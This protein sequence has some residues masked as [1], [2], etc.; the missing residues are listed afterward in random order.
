MGA[1]KFQAIDLQAKW[2]PQNPPPLC[3]HLKVESER[4]V[5]GDVTDHNHCTRLWAVSSPL[6]R[7]ADPVR[8]KTHNG[9]V[10]NEAVEKA[11]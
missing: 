10:V 9:N 6:M 4:N 11:R 5:D 2:K 8:R 3:E 7:V 1:T